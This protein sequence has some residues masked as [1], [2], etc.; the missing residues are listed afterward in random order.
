MQPAIRLR[1]E[2]S[3]LHVFR[4]QRR[5][6]LL[7]FGMLLDTGVAMP[8]TTAAPADKGGKKKK[9][10]KQAAGGQEED[11]DAILQELGEQAGPSHQAPNSAAEPGQDADVEGTAAAADGNDEE[12]EPGRVS[13]WP[14]ADL[15]AVLM[16][17]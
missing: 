1:A 2:V 7:M 12:A 8:A 15:P 9:K 13:F 11:I 4:L 6:S 3:L 5:Y 10:G 14:K 16:S 17:C